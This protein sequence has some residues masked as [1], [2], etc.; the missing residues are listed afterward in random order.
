MSNSKFMSHLHTK[1]SISCLLNV[2][3]DETL[4]PNNMMTK[5]SQCPELTQC[6]SHCAQER[7]YFVSP[8]KCGSRDCIICKPPR[9][10]NQDFKCLNHLPNPIPGTD[11]NYKEFR[12]LFGT[13]TTE[14]AMPSLKI[15][16][17]HGHKIPFNPVKHHTSN[18]GLITD[19]NECSKP[20]LVYTAKRLME[21]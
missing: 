16:K 5:F 8:K 13:V 15:S 18:T 1:K 9:L 20:Q 21:D 2:G 7:T 17:V 3:L 14:S 12:E 11:D 19:C 4:K 10:N 6:L